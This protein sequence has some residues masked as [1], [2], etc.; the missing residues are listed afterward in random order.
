MPTTRTRGEI[1]IDQL[2]LKKYKW[3]PVFN[4][5]DTNA[6]NPKENNSEGDLITQ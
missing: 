1:L 6:R 4:I 3:Q 2:N 5:D